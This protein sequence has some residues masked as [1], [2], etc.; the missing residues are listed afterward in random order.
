MKQEQHKNL[1]ELIRSEYRYMF[2][3]GYVKG[4]NCDHLTDKDKFNEGSIQYQVDC[5]FGRLINKY[6]YKRIENFI[7]AFKELQ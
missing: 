6:E 3:N 1:E 2:W 4:I 5:E 7:K